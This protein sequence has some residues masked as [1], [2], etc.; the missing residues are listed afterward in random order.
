[1]FFEL[2]GVHDLSAQSVKIGPEV[3]CQEVDSILT[4]FFLV[5]QNNITVM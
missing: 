4:I 2:A 3:E 5:L 1:M